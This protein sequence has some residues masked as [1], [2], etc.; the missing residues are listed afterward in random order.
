MKKILI[1]LVVALLCVS[2]AAPA[3]ATDFTP[4]VENKPA[5]SIVP[6][7][8]EDGNPRPG[9]ILDEDGNIISYLDED[10]LVMT[11]VA[12]ADI[13]TEIPKD[14]KNLL[15]WL[16]QQLV[17]GDMKM[18]YE[19]HNPTYGPDDMAIRDLFDVTF[20]CGD[21]PEMLEAVGVVLVLTFDLGVKPDQDV[22]VMTYKEEDG[23]WADIHDI[24]NNGDGT[25]T[26]VFE[27]LCPVAF[28]VAT[29]DGPIQTGDTDTFSVWGIVALGA[30]VA[31]AV[32]TYVYYRSTKKSAA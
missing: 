22:S 4:S 9:V 15:L 26:C 20:L 7:I 17:K 2:M 29:G 31:I 16:Y 21:H 3:Y 32:L 25:V 13:S 27:H 12:D 28:S 6:V 5:P 1:C 8:D 24:T 10:C 11:S 19:L 18:P 30:L 14:A 23:G